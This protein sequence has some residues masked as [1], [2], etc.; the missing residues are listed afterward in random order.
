VKHS[1][2]KQKQSQH[3][4][5]IVN[6]G[7]EKKKRRKRKTR[8]HKEPS[9]EAQ[10]YAESI[11][12]I[13]PRIQYNF[14]Q[15]SSFNY[16]A[17]KTPALVRQPE[18]E[19]S[20]YVVGTRPGLRVATDAIGV[21]AVPILANVSVN[22]SE[23][24][25]QEMEKGFKGGFDKEF[26]DKYETPNDLQISK[27]EPSALGKFLAINHKDI[28]EGLTDGFDRF[29]KAS[30]A[31]LAKP[32][33]SAKMSEEAEEEEAIKSEEAFQRYLEKEKKMLEKSSKKKEP[34][35]SALSTKIYKPRE[36]TIQKLLEDEQL[37][38]TRSNRKMVT[39][40]YLSARQA[41]TA[42]ELRKERLKKLRTSVPKG[43]EKTGSGLAP[44][45]EKEETQLVPIVGKKK[46]KSLIQEIAS[47][48]SP[49]AS[50]EKEE[51]EEEEE[52]GEKKSGGLAKT[53]KHV[54][55]KA[56]QAGATTYA[57]TKSAKAAAVTAAVGGLSAFFD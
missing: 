28:Y 44:I 53:L 46:E 27:P 18:S 39:E 10:E 23:N 20:K 13:V 6:I 41:S 57:T 31:D 3:Q 52:G 8:R 7:G 21:Q 1:H 26:T 49:K 17:Y 33:E 34:L 43:S 47:A 32:E 9:Q 45:L 11:S 36:S 38:D 25:A 42:A 24:L 4:K 16:D 30:S 51:E 50:P 37:P 55:A 54:G 48:V 40:K 19:T 56:F 14:P 5:V 15:H 2:H 29:E 35:L 22:E 12:R